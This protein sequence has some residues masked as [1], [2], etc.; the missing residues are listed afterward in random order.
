M[1]RFD[2]CNV[3]QGVERCSDAGPPVEMGV[4]VVSSELHKYLSLVGSDE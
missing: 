3:L 4:E 1:I 2:L